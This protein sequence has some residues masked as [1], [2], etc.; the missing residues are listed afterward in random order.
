MT[1]TKLE[2]LCPICNNFDSIRY[3]EHPNFKGY[4]KAKH[5]ALT[6]LDWGACLDY[7]PVIPKIEVLASD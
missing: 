1:N 4:C 2:E 3:A 7:A 5:I 6:R